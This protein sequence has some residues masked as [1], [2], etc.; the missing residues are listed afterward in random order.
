V[1][2]RHFVHDGHLRVSVAGAL[3][4][5]VIDAYVTELR[6]SAPRPRDSHRSGRS[7]NPGPTRRSPLSGNRRVPRTAR[8][9]DK[10]PQTSRDLGIVNDTSTSR[11]GEVSAPW[12]RRA[13]RGRRSPAGRGCRGEPVRSSH[14]RS[15]LGWC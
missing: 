10:Q 8:W 12:S 15:P 7:P 3:G 14:G 1:D 11:D 6:T 9:Q 4:V 5:S 2:G 13:G